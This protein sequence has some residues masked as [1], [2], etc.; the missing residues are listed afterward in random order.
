[1][2][3]PAP[4]VQATAPCPCHHPM[5]RPL[6]HVQATSP[7]PDHCPMSRPL[8]HVY[9]PMS[10]RMPPCP[11]H[12]P[13]LRSLLTHLAKGHMWAFVI[14]WRS[15]S[16]V[17]LSVASRKLLLLWNHWTKLNLTRLGWSLCGS[18]SKLCLSFKLVVV[19]KNRNFFNC[20][21]LLYYKQKQVKF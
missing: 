21:L 7:C 19:T 3:R 13:M 1:M 4:H 10:R 18:L 20:P 16:F 12:C 6:P 2:S 14:S 9:C 11:G 17:R 8:P 5:S 15:S